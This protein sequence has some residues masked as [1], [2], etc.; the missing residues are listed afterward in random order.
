M[1]IARNLYYLIVDFNCFYETLLYFTVDVCQVDLQMEYIPWSTKVFHLYDFCSFK[2]LEIMNKDLKRM[3]GA[4]Q[5]FSLYWLILSTLLLVMKI[6]SISEEVII[7]VKAMKHFNSLYLEY[8]RVSQIKW[9]GAKCYN[10][11]VIATNP[12]YSQKFPKTYV[13]WKRKPT[14]VFSV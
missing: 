5:T 8:Y 13:P 12:F 3:L 14:A 11:L 10:V 1:L 6:T 4:G 9:C 7:K 2:Y